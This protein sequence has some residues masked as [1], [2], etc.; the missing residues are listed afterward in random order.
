MGMG[1]GTITAAVTDPLDRIKTHLQTQRMG[2]VIPGAIPNPFGMENSAT[3]SG[4]RTS[5]GKERHVP[6]W[7]FEMLRA[8]YF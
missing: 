6:K 5:K 8:L 7:S 3:N 4:G 1:A 2:M